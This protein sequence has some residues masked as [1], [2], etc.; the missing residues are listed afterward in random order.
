MQ[1]KFKRH[2]PI[3]LL[4][5]PNPEYIEYH[6]DIGEEGEKPIIKKGMRGKINM[7]LPN[8]KYHVQIEDSKGSMIAYAEVEEEEIEPI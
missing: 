6:S 2:Q 4:R 1:T 5:D 7:I 3:I 8:G